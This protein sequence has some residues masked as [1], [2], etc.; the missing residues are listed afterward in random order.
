MKPP[1][2]LADDLSGAL[3]AGAAFL[4][5]GWRPY[6][7]VGDPGVATVG[8]GELLVLSSETRNAAP[9]TARATV[10]RLLALP[11]VR[12]RELL[13]KKVDS[14]LRGP[15]GAELAA[16]QEALP[17]RRIFLCPANP[18]TG[19]TVRAGRLLVKGVPVDQTEFG[20]DPLS[21][22]GTADIVQLL[23]G[24]GVRAHRDGLEVADSV[25]VC[26]ADD[27]E[28]LRQLVMRA[29]AMNPP[30]LLVGSGALGALLAAD[31]RQPAAPIAEWR[32][33]DSLLVICGSRHPQSLRQMAELAGTGVTVISVS[34]D[35][36]PA[37]VAETLA[38]AREK[39]AVVGVTF[40]VE[41]VSDAAS[42][43]Q[44]W[45]VRLAR[46]VDERGIFS[47]LGL[48]GGETAAAVVHA[49][50]ADRLEV[51]AEFEPGVISSSLVRAGRP[52]L[53]VITKPGG[54]GANG[55]WAGIVRRSLK[56][57]SS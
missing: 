44:A 56:Q 32:A 7:P 8:E 21:P 28:A 53:R 30:G 54:Y 12:Q 48:T 31:R 47:T 5:A 37:V 6:V 33:P 14:T 18:L 40:Q 51:R 29:R 45:I 24:Q 43:V 3:E 34:L 20:H 50:G 2:V 41:G 27:L 19:R 52:G 17:G 9:A 10:A 4:A 11:G 1:F 38:R 42:A 15:I 55:L 23:E 35:Q 57:N 13:F 25:C 49:L 22:I 26:D 36:E 16:L 39:S 46:A